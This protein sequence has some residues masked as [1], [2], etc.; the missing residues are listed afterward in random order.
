MPAIEII[1]EGEDGFDLDAVVDESPPPTPPPKTARAGPASAARSPGGRAF[2][3]SSS[4]AGRRPGY[5]FKTGPSGTGYYPDGNVS[6]AVAATF[7]EPATPATPPPSAKLSLL[8]PS[9][10]AD[11]EPHS[12]EVT[13]A[14]GGL[15]PKDLD[16]RMKSDGKLDVRSERWTA[17]LKADLG[18]A[19][20]PDLAEAWVHDGVATLRVPVAAA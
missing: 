6:D 5:A 15:A 2:H 10:S 13:F 9:G 14:A 7:G 1:E 16:I 19:V 3:P 20:A 17:S 11:A 18:H 8:Q 4:F 12:V